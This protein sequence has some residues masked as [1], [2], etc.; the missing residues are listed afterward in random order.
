[1]GTNYNP[2]IVT[3]GLVLAL[4]AANPKSYPGSGTSWNDLSGNGNHLTLYNSPTFASTNRGTI[5]FNGTSQYAGI[6]NTSCS[7]NFKSMP[8]GYTTTIG[9]RSNETA[10]GAWHSICSFGD[11]LNYIDLWYSAATGN[12][13]SDAQS[14][15]PSTASLIN[16]GFNIYTHSYS[17]TVS[18]IY[19]NGVLLEIRNITQGVLASG[20]YN[21]CIAASPETP[22]AYY[23]NMDVNFFTIYNTVLTDEQVLQNFNAQRGRYDI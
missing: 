12:F 8:N 19:K 21:F 13:G 9:F 11:G 7:N 17:G 3:S 1:M 2:Q 20:Q 22:I 16:A 6:A 23:H 10:T 4:D 14:H 15:Y 18:K 5:S